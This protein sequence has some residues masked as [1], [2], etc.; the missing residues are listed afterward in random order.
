MGHLN[1]HR[2][3]LGR[4]VTGKS[5]HQPL[6]ACT[7]R[8]NALSDIRGLCSDRVYHATGVRVIPKLRVVIPDLMDRIANNGLIIDLRRRC[9]L[10]RNHRKAGR[11]KRLTRDPSHRILLEDRIQDSVRNVVGDLIGMALSHRFRSE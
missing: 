5:E 2:H 6:I 9:D 10:A 4:L 8:I 7:T 1:G 3:Q 11:Y